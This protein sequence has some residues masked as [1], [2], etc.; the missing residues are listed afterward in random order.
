MED[1]ESYRYRRREAAWRDIKEKV[2]EDIYY[3]MEKNIK[4]EA[5]KELGIKE[6]D[7]V[8]IIQTELDYIRI[9]YKET[10]K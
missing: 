4:S 9:R 3:L 1:K 10:K 6:K 2:A 7:V 5:G 8:K